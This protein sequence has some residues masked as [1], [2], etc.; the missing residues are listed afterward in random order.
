MA[1]FND[2]DADSNVEEI[3]IRLER[4]NEILGEHGNLDWLTGKGNFVILNNGIEFSITYLVML[5]ALFFSGGG[6]Y[7]SVDYWLGELTRDS[8]PTRRIRRA[9]RRRR[10]RRRPQPE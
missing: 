3:S 1:D 7:V 10:Y 4:A 5:V 8:A 9:R 2:T 6:R